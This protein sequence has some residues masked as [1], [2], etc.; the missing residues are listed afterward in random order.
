M[1]RLLVLVLALTLCGIVSASADE[2]VRAAQTRLK[3][4]GF[5]FGEPNG[6]YNT[7]TAAA[8]SRYQIRNGLQITGQLDAATS[9][10][11]GVRATAVN[12]PAPAADSDSWRRL[13]KTDPQFLARQNAGRTQEPPA[14]KRVAARP[15][16]PAP[17]PAGGEVRDQG[18]QTFTLSRERLRDYVG[19]FVLAGI[20]PQVGAELEFFADRVTY[21]DQGIVGRD[22]IRRDLRSYNDQWPERRFWLAGNVNV[23]PQPDSRLRVSF[24]LRYELRRSGKRASGKIQKTL[25]LEV[26]SDDLQIVAVNERK[27][28]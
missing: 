15:A 17:I 19:A 22:K 28:R 6:N 13:R 2:N 4:G 12:V 18:Y 21:Y 27:L 1:K 8:V 20:D 11:L 5:Y 9:K 25:L 23:E 10:S 16:A 7:E 26:T 24:P 14:K 3:E